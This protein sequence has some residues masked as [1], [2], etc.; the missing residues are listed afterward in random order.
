MLLQVNDIVTYKNKNSGAIFTASLE[1]EIQYPLF[2]VL[3]IDTVSAVNKRMIGETYQVNFDEKY[4]NIEILD[5][6]K[7]EEKLAEAEAQ[8]YLSLCHLAVDRNDEQWF[9][10]CHAYYALWNSKIGVQA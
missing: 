4:R 1:R 9:R 5:V 6:K 8:K 10:E 2:D 7:F 3:I